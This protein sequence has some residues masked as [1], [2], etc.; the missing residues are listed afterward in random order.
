[1]FTHNVVYLNPHGSNRQ[2]VFNRTEQSLQTILENYD[3]ILGQDVLMSF[4]KFTLNFENMYFFLRTNTHYM[5]SA[6]KM[7]VK[8]KITERIKRIPPVINGIND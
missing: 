6:L 2:N 1:M 4:N 8:D 3:G 5:K 7:E